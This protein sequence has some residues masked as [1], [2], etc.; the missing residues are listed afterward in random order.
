MEVTETLGERFRWGQVENCG[1][2]CMEERV[3]D[4]AKADREVVMCLLVYKL[5][6]D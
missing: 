3:E 1:S 5:D 4:D 6:Q 2:D